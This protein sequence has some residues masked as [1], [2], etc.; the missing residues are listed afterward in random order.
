MICPSS[1]QR[2]A[3]LAE[4]E[5]CAV[6]Q[7]QAHQRYIWRLFEPT[8]AGRCCQACTGI[9]RY[10]RRDKTWRLQAGRPPFITAAI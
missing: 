8:R 7:E 4:R 6:A 9:L 10:E 5:A 1:S 3:K 2:V